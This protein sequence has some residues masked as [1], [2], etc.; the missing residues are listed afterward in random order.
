[1]AQPRVA[2]V[3]DVL[4]RPEL[5]QADGGEVGQPASG[6]GAGGRQPEVVAAPDERWSINASGSPLLGVG[7]TGDVLAGLIGS[8]L[9]QGVPAYDAARLGVFLHGRA[10]DRL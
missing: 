3:G 8:L 5:G 7:G 9:A 6:L 1:M 2:R 10:G 4:V